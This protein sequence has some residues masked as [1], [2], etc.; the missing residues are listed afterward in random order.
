MKRAV[1]LLLQ[2]SYQE[3]L[4]CL[5]PVFIFLSLALSKLIIV[6]GLARYDLLLLLLLSVSGL[7]GEKRFGNT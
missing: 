5:F 3:A 4:S 1:W 2:F 6:P 7:H